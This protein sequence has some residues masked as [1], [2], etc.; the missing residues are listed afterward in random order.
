MGLTTWV[1]FVCIA[2][3]PGTKWNNLDFYAVQHQEVLTEKDSLADEDDGFQ[4]LRDKSPRE[5]DVRVDMQF[6]KSGNAMNDSVC[7]RINTMIIE[8]LLKQPGEQSADKA[9][10]QY[11]ELMKAEF[12]GDPV[13][14]TY[15]DHLTGRA[16]YGFEDIINYRLE[17]E[18]FT[19]GAHPCTITTILRFNALTGDF[20]SLA[21]VF[22]LEKQTS[23]KLLL[24]DKLMADNG[25]STLEALHSKGYLEMM[26][27]FVSSNFALREDS[28]EFY[29][30]VY[31]IAPYVYGPTAICLSYEEA[32][33]LMN[34]FGEVH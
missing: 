31:D 20:I 18:V 27:M 8:M 11:I 22:P 29:Y 12:R 32:E 10:K 30:N 5:M 6:I 17:E 26:D 24:Q 23:L 34:S 19:G 13:V 28:I 21:N 14:K 15:Y 33:P 9:V 4:A 25:V 1:A 2:C 3:T 16:E 7:R